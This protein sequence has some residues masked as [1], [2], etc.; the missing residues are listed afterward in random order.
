MTEQARAHDVEILHT[1]DAP[2]VRVFDA[3]LDPA[4]VQQWFGPGL[5]ETQPVEIDARVGG[6]FRIV[7]I[8]EGQGLVGHSGQYLALDRPGHL[9]FTWATDDDDGHDEVHVYI[10]RSTHGSSVRLVHSVD[11]RWKEYAERIRSSWSAMLG[12]MDALL[13]G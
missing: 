3:W 11:E 2:P 6:S 7:Q 8:R 12:E 4:L 1:I 9:A 5:G 10:A 13:T